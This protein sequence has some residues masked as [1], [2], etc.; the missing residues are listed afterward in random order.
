[1]SFT[2]YLHFQGNCCEAM[3]FYGEVFGAKPNIM[4]YSDA[5]PDADFKPSDLVMHSDLMVGGA[6]LMASDYPPGMEG[7]PQASVSVAGILP[8]LSAAESAY[9]RLCEGGTPMMPFGPTFWSPGFGMLK[10]RF[11]THWMIMVPDEGP[12]PT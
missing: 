11:G 6:L 7:E 4:T 1:M 10:D 2:P 9:D 12:P 5:P 8:D 3:T